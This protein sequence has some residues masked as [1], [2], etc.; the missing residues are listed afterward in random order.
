M[1]IEEQHVAL[2]KLYGAPAYGRP[3]RGVDVSPRPLDPDDLPIAA[4]QT[5]EERELAERLPHEGATDGHGN[6]GELKA[7]PFRLRALVSR[8]L[9]G[10]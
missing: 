10:N 4:Y 7:R 2:P 8:I 6:S 9:P 5:D 1:S 3:R